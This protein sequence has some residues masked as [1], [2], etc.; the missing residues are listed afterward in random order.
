MQPFRAV[1][2]PGQYDVRKNVTSDES[3]WTFADDSGTFE[4]GKLIRSKPIHEANIH[5]CPYPSY[6]CRFGNSFLLIPTLFVGSAYNNRV[7]DNSMASGVAMYGAQPNSQQL[8]SLAYKSGSKR[9]AEEFEGPYSASNVYPNK[10]LRAS[11]DFIIPQ[12]IN[13]EATVR[14]GNVVRKNLSIFEL[15]RKSNVTIYLNGFLNRRTVLIMQFL[16]FTPFSRR[17]NFF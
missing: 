13:Y 6:F 9:N 1:P 2:S 10:K 11:E 7:P 17:S 12:Q 5:Y 4:E 8:Q 14:I 16:I 3:E 15:F